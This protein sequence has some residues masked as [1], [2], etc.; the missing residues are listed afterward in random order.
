LGS[1][2]TAVLTINDTA[3]QI[4]NPTPI[5]FTSNA[6]ASPYPSTIN[7]TGGPASV[8]SMRVTLYDLSHTFPD[9]IDVLL[10]GPNG[11]KYVLMA[12]AG[13]ALPV[14]INATA[15]LT[16]S[17]AGGAVLPDSAQLA[18]GEF[19]PTT[20]ETPVTN[21]PAPAPAGPYIEPG[22]LLSRPTGLTMFGNFGLQNSNG[23]WSLYVRDDSGFPITGQIAGG[24]GLEILPSTAPGVSVSGRV[25]T[26]DGRGLRNATVTITD[27]NGVSRPVTTSSFGFFQFDDVAP[28]GTYTIRVFSRFFR[29][30]PR[31]VQVTGN[32]TLA[33]FNGLE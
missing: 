15:T 9:N 27:Q 22:S 31:T 8:G 29:F 28:G 30:A 26:A 18:T 2:N 17:D 24:W 23:T 14:G 4:R 10:V 20:L 12:D 1:Q 7:V 5:T 25:L 21:F 6:A 32:L 3:S 19:K 16:F 13:G 33:D 11:A